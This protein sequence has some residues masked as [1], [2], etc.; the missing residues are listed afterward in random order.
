MLRCHLPSNATLDALYFHSFEHLVDAETVTGLR[1]WV[2]LVEGLTASSMMDV[3]VS[4]PLERPS[5]QDLL[6]DFAIS[7]S[8]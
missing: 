8:E 2:G 6:F 1:I 3:T 4:S 7:L 5:L